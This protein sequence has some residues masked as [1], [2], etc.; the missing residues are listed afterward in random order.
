MGHFTLKIQNLNI[1]ENS[2]SVF[3]ILFFAAFQ[4][5]GQSTDKKIKCIVHHFG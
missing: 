4:A 2:V 5:T 1:V 3:F